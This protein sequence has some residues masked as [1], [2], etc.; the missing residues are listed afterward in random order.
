M[1]SMKSR[2]DIKDKIAVITGANR[3]I[4]R[5]IADVF[6]REG[7]TKIYAA[8]RDV[9]S[10]GPL[11]EQYGNRVIPVHL[12]LARQETISA[13]AESA[14]D[15]QIVVNNAAVFMARTPLDGDAIEALELAIR[16]NVFGLMH[17]GQAFAPTLKRNGGGAFVQI[18]SVASLKCSSG[19]ATH[20][21]SKAAAYS[22][23]QAL[24]ELLGQQGTLV[25]S[26]HPG[27]IATGMADSAG[28]NRAAE[29]PLVVAEEIVAGLKSGHFHLFPDSV[30]KRV[31]HAY[32]SFAKNVIEADIPEY[33]T[34]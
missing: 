33:R 6:L 4:G 3:G 26:V 24:R 8:V 19:F 22:I 11:V 7:A 29:S 13:L 27:L 21:A 17:M 30:A 23:T 9:H 16:I 2:Y 31:G 28:L 34:E 12:D 20:S 25:L 14:S 5:A 32:E 1:N 15:A 18:N 10:A